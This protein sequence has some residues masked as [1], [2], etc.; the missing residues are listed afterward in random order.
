[1]INKIFTVYD[2][3]AKA[4]ITPF[5]IPEEGMATRL[6]EQ[7]VNNTE[8]QFGKAPH[9]YTLFIVGTFDDSNAEIKY[10]TPQSLGNGLEFVATQPT[11]TDNVQPIQQG[12][13][14]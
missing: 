9:D 14:S 11:N 4:Y 5:F 10:Q 7:S 13:A 1:M 3:K 6:F 2:V 12:T 8:H